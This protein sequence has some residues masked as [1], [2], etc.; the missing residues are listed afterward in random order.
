MWAEGLAVFYEVFQ[1]LEGALDRHSH[2]LIGE[3]DIPGMRRIEA[4]E[5]VSYI[6]FLVVSYEFDNKSWHNEPLINLCYLMIVI[7]R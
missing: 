5:K 7:D 2:T 3:L 4:F 1:Y 6:D